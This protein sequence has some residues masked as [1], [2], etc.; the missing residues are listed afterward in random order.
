MS[1]WTFTGQIVLIAG[2]TLVTYLP[3]VL[4]LWLLSSRQLSPAVMR[5]L[6]M[7]PP[8]VLAALL[9][10]SLFL[11]TGD[12]GAERLFLGLDNVFLLASVPAF[13]VAWRA[14]SFFG[15]V[16]MGMASVALCRLLIPFPD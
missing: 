15:T 13:L 6:E 1:E 5:W 2:M 16:A 7:V 9:A 14:R 4:P 8:A 11:R 10:P 12:D 3:R